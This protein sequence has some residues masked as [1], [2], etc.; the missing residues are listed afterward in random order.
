MQEIDT[1]NT[2]VINL[3]APDINQSETKQHHQQQQQQQHSNAEFN[4]DSEIVLNKVLLHFISFY[5]LYYSNNTHYN[6]ITVK[7]GQSRSSGN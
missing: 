7:L 4:K 2:K 6:L 1:K 5:K 3:F